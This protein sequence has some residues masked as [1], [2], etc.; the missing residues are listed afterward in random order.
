[1]QLLLG[2][3][4]TFL[5]L[6]TGALLS[7]AEALAPGEAHAQTALAGQSFVP[8]GITGRSTLP[9]NT[10]IR[11]AEGRAIA[12]F[13]GGETTV[14][15]SGFTLRTAAKARVE[16]GSGRGAFR[17]RGFID[18]SALPFFTKQEL[19]VT[20]NFVRIGKDRQVTVVGT[21][22]T[23]LR[24]ERVSSPPAKVTLATFTPCSSLK[25]TPGT[26]PG[27]SPAGFARGYMLKQDSVELW[28]GPQ[29]SSVG[30]LFKTP[31]AD[32]LLFFSN[33]QSGSMV[34]VEYHADVVVDAW[35]RASD[36]SALPPGETM[37]QIA[38][39]PSQRGTPRLALPGNP[40]VV[41]ALREVA[42]RGAAKDNTPI[43]GV[44][45]PDAEAYVIDVMAGWVSVMPKALD[46][47]PP[48]GG[49]F[50]VKKSELG[51]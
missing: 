26:P 4:L 29:G 49:A 41:R 34:H 28:S 1:M 10:V 6:A 13:S 46:V 42:L 19:P 3:R 2:K 40:R 21:N 45:E 43:V 36:L 8:C 35:V 23:D 25:L 51:I 7:A 48:D 27:W 20:K 22:G 37:D 30:T 32:A 18:T 9:L 47:V 50:W 14:T 44:I 11:D 5:G 15:V 24:I 33:E 38:S 39:L 12:R 31:G 16:T 17:V